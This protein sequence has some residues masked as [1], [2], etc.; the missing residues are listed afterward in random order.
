[1]MV[2]T[3]RAMAMVR[4]R[5]NSVM[6]V[7]MCS[8]LISLTGFLPIAGKMWLFSAPLNPAM[9]LVTSSA[10]LNANYCLATSQK[11]APG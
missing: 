2:R 9:D 11:C 1:M 5:R 7:V 3:R 6:I 8:S 10:D 4:W